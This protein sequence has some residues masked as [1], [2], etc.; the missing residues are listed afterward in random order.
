M[1]EDSV[2]NV[3]ACVVVVHQ[4]GGGSALEEDKEGAGSS[5]HQ[6]PWNMVFLEETEEENSWIEN[7]VVHQPL[8]SCFRHAVAFPGAWG[9]NMVHQDEDNDV[10]A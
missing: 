2:H 9:H 6:V 8:P 3:D 7:Q 1:V 4:D 5:D 10:E